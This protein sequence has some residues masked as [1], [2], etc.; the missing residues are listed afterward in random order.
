[1]NIDLVILDMLQKIHV[2]ILD[3][4]MIFFTLIGNLGLVWIGLGMLLIVRKKTRVYGMILLISLAITAILGEGIL[5]HLI[6]RERPFEIISGIKTLI[7]L[8][9]SYSFP[10][11]HTSSSF[12]A[13]GVFYFLN[14]KYKWWVFITAFLIAFSRMYLGVHYFT[15]ILG[16]II[17][18]TAV[19]YIVCLVYKKREKYINV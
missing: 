11:G 14:L 9:S 7:K 17:L 8:P 3:Q 15:D 13:F 18:G 19:A 16:G 1:M 5:K 6:R 10:S 12:T 2:H 4:I